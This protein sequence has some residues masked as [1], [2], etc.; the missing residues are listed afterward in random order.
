MHLAARTAPLGG[1]EEQYRLLMQSV[2]DHAIFFLDAEGNVAAWNAGACRMFGY[3]AEEALGLPF[4]VFFNEED[5]QKRE[6][7][8]ELSRAAAE[9]RAS[10]DRWHVRKDGT[11]LWVNGVT[12]ALW[13][14]DGKLHGFAKVTRDRT[15]HRRLEGEARQRAAELAEAGRRKDEFLAMLAHELRNPLAPIRDA[16][17]VLRLRGPQDPDLERCRDVI[18]RQVGHLTRL[19]DD[20]LDV[21]RISQ[22]KVVLQKGAV[23]LAT[24]VAHAVEACRP[25]IESRRQELT[26]T[27]SLSPLW[28]EADRTRLVQVVTNLL[29]NAAKYTPEG[30]HVWLTAEREG[31]EVVVRVRD[32]GVG[33]S[34]DLLPSVF[35]LFTQGKPSLREAQG[36]LGVGLTLVKSLVELHGGR[37]EARSEG[38]GK[39]SEF[40]VRLPALNEQPQAP[41]TGET[42]QEKE[43]PSPARRVLVVDDNVD[44]AESL[45]TLLRLKGHEVRTAHRASEVL[46]A[47]ATFHPE[48]VLLDIGLPGEVSGHDLAPRLRQMTGLEEALLVALT[49]FGQEEDRRQS[50]QAGF[51]VHLTKPADLATLHALLADGRP[52]R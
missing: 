39:G 10:D 1:P 30:G 43:G 46:E 36:G 23:E 52:A 32:D 41:A 4:A 18:D 6:H 16:A 37:V 12:T 34:P 5:R 42:S 38:L 49:G 11:N 7:E 24:A 21:S 8:K 44:A 45:A 33:I 29:N 51:D 47:A 50:Q 17:Q 15:E 27:L 20:L 25:L 48:V 40:V 28:L 3:T 2:S 19:V 35:D 31:C 9:G 26:V 22:G 13:D 14:E